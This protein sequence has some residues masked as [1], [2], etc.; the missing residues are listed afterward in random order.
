MAQYL[1]Q[2]SYSQEAWA[3]LVNNPQNRIRGS[4]SSGAE[5]RRKAGTGR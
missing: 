3:S 5:A 2:V 1:V 4:F